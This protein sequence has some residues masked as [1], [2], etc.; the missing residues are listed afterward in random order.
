MHLC[1]VHFLRSAI[2]YN[3]EELKKA[4][5]IVSNIF[6]FS[7][8]LLQHSSSIEYFT[9]I[10]EKIYIIFNSPNYD[11]RLSEAIKFLRIEIVNRSELVE[12]PHHMK[13]RELKK[14]IPDPEMKTLRQK[15]LLLASSIF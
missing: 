5:S 15:S 1:H 8:S 3:K 11:S 12:S 9:N 4:N 7:F 6:K 13:Q 14:N 2:R 10:L